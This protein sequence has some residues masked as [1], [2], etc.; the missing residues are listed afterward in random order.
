MRASSSAERR[1]GPTDA[2]RRRAA[3]NPIAPIKH[4]ERREP[5]EQRMRGHARPEQHELAVAR[6]EEIN[7]LAVAV[8]RSEA[9]AHQH[10]HVLRERRIGSSID[11]FWQTM[12]R[13]SWESARARASSFRS[14]R[15]SSGCT[16]SAGVPAGHDQRQQDMRA[17]CAPSLDQDIAICDISLCGGSPSRQRQRSQWLKLSQEVRQ[18]V[19]ARLEQ[20]AEDRPRR[21]EGG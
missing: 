10:A 12:Q 11:W 1:S 9:L 16:A 13:S 7:H 17:Q 3:R 14:F 2:V 19:N 4:R 21:R 20:F 5:Q 8:A 15:T 18:R 6:N